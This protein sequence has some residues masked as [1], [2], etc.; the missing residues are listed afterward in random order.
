MASG[1]FFN[2]WTE[3][4]FTSETDLLLKISHLSIPYIECI[5]S[6]HNTVEDPEAVMIQGLVCVTKI[7]TLGG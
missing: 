3:G 4:S 2:S 5:H 1:N 7:P 6:G